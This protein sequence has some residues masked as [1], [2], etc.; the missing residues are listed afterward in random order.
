M[1]TREL[2]TN[3]YSMLSR[4]LVVCSGVF[5]IILFG[6]QAA[7]A[8]GSVSVDQVVGNVT[9]TGVSDFGW[10]HTVDPNDEGSL[11]AIAVTLAMKT[12]VGVVFD[13]QYDGVSMAQAVSLNS[14][15]ANTRSEIW[16]LTNPPQGTHEVHVFMFAPREVVA[17]SISMFG[18]DQVVP[19]R[20]QTSGN[21]IGSNRATAQITSRT[22]DL[23]I[24]CVAISGNLTGFFDPMDT[25]P[26]GVDQTERTN[27]ATGAGTSANVRGLVSTEPGMSAMDGSDGNVVMDWTLSAS[28]NWVTTIVMVKPAIRLS[29][30]LVSFNA[31]G[32][33]SAMS[34]PGGVQLRWTTGFEADNLGY[35]VYRETTAG[36]RVPVARGLIAGSAL[37]S[38]NST[39]SAGNSYSLFDPSG[40]TA[41]RYW[42]ESLD[43]NGAKSLRG[44]I[45][46]TPV[47][48]EPPAAKNA[49]LLASAVGSDSSHLL[50]FGVASDDTGSTVFGSTARKGS[51]GQLTTQ[52]SLAGRPAL[53]LGVRAQ[54]W[55][56]V[57][58]Q[59][60]VSAGLDPSKISPATLQLFAEGQEQTILVTGADDNR[61]DP[62]DSIEFYATGLN[63]Q[64]TD[65]RV[66]WLV[67][68][69]QA[70]KRVK[71]S[72]T[73]ASRGEARSFLATA[74]LKERL[75][76]FPLL[77][78]GE[79][80]NF[81]G[82]VVTSDVVDQTVT[83]QRLDRSAP[84]TRLEVALQG[85]TNDAHNVGVSINGQS[86]G[87]VVF[88][89]R[90]RGVSTLTIPSSLVQE[91]ANVVSL[92]A[93][94]GESDASLVDYVRITYLHAAQ[95]DADKLALTTSG[96]LPLTLG[97]FTDARIHVVD[98]STPGAPVVLSGP[99]TPVG[100]NF[101]ITVQPS[102]A[103]NRNLIAFTDATM[104]RPD[105][106]TANNPS[107]WNRSH[108]ADVVIVAH[109]DFLGA[110]NNLKAL[111][112]SQGYRV[113]VI[114]VEDLYDE[115]S[116]GDVTPQAIKGFLSATRSGW[117]TA[118]R[119]V[120][121]IGDGSFD[122]KEYLGSGGRS[123]V[124]VKLL[125]T[126]MLETASDDWFVDFSNRDLP[127]MA[128]GR[129]PVRTS[130]E[131]LS[132]VGKIAAYESSSRGSH[133]ALLVADTPDA[134]SF[135]STSAGV[136]A[137][138]PADFAVQTVYRR[139]T[140]DVVGR[141]QVLAGID[142][143][144]GLV[145]FVGHGSVAFWRGGLLTADDAPSL[146]NGQ[147][148]SF[149]VMSNCLNGYFQDPQLSS[150]GEA[151]L[152]SQSGGAVG[153]WA[154]S[155]MTDPELQR[156]LTD[157]FYRQL[158]ASPQ[159]TVGEAAMRAKS[160]VPAEL[161]RSWILLGDPLTRVQ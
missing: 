59:D 82:D 154:T 90:G 40:T 65:T 123:F 98:V 18:V 107:S 112:Q 156:V 30:S 118:P 149:F 130:A 127:E 157:E 44:P 114:D 34:R 135:E 11:R 158:F 48:G 120:V 28:T 121:F 54:G 105:S 108:T 29:A 104:L 78:N 51:G 81:F 80:E 4:L 60:L 31:E 27:T 99:V 19:L 56:R 95:A 89:G 126:E 152:R 150:L 142:A 1:E 79:A 109:R 96:R 133:S 88:S 155:G 50:A 47:E 15:V 94:G 35:R 53:K 64:S 147:S 32:Y 46:V 144:P 14:N 125:D 132:V 143:G 159:V 103:P 67:S 36:D 139:L 113:E 97:G 5:A 116:F 69:A 73:S 111:R 20:S 17:T 58:Y 106:I 42:L 160:V 8:Q 151:L 33:S 63:L 84:T 37:F 2:V 22:G 9:S 49:P 76:Y 115:Y 86:V 68:G 21:N 153:V 145:N 38:K 128:I 16:I 140:G 92:A 3:R 117:A 91:G 146:S 7:R 134:S 83:V 141:Q 12:T 71:V 72:S 26:T 25:P 62:Q 100:G 45:S 85:V 110:A 41:S 136:Q 75:I 13:V 23:G 6:A 39:L 77:A 124:P 161:R 74:E 10:N 87:S 119:Y 137:L 57:S 43:V 66:Y 24:D 55:Y 129:I 101:S 102:S 52:Q 148:L 70:G 138:L 122:P 61:F 93:T 131:A